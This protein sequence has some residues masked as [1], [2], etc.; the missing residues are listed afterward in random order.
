R[1][2]RYVQKIFRHE[3]IAF[4]HRARS[5]LSLH[6][7]AAPG[8]LGS[9]ALWHQERRG[10][11]TALGRGWY[12]QNNHLP[13][14]SRNAHQKYRRS[15][16]HTSLALGRGTACCGVRRIRHQLSEENEHQ[17]T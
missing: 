13:A 17:G 11:R 9:S 3:K 2:E 4:F 7:R 14:P 16:H 10:V 5:A 1:V 8:G 15:L 6:E 12:G